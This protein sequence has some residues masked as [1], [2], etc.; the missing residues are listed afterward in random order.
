MQVRLYVKVGYPIPTL[1]RQDYD[2]PAALPLPQGGDYVT[3]GPD[4]LQVEHREF[5]PDRVPLV[6]I[7]FL[8]IDQKLDG[9]GW[10]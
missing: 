7:S 6:G 5:W 3:I 9:E 2:W 10:T 1:M 8:P 4:E